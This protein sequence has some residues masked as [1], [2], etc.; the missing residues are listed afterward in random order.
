MIA[1]WKRAYA[2]VRPVLSV[3]GLPLL[4]IGAIVVGSELASP[5]GSSLVGE[6]APELALPTVAGVGSATGDRVRLSDLRGQVVLL[7]FWASWCGP[8][9]QSIPVL[10]RARASH[11]EVQF[12]GVNVEQ[13]DPVRLARAHEALGATFPSVQDRSGEVQAAFGVLSLPTC[14]LI[15]REGIVRWFDVGVPDGDELARQ[16]ERA[17]D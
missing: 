8:C 15:D 6:P 14:I 13:L 12:L 3:V 10:N 17:L 9:R 7:D 11:P 1:F 5:P 16:I 2:K 4:V